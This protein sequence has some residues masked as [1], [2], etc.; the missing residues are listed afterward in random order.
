MSPPNFCFLG[1]MTFFLFPL[2][3]G[4]FSPEKIFLNLI[5]WYNMF[6]PASFAD[7]LSTVCSLLCIYSNNTVQCSHAAY[8]FDW[9]FSLKMTLQLPTE[10]QNN[11]QTKTHIISFTLYNWFKIPYTAW[12]TSIKFKTSYLKGKSMKPS[13]AKITMPSYFSLCSC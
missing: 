11:R 4:P 8:L 5:L 7:F 6:I 10:K 2:S 13:V 1:H 12:R 9:F 3:H